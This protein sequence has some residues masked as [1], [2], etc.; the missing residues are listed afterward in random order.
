MYLNKI[1][2]K[3]NQWGNHWGKPANTQKH[4]M[5]TLKSIKIIIQRDFGK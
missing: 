4:H 3:E 5:S 1:K 2:Y